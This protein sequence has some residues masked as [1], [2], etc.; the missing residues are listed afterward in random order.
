MITLLAVVLCIVLAAIAVLGALAIRA[1]TLACLAAFAR[2]LLA[3]AIGSLARVAMVARR[4]TVAMTALAP[5]TRSAT[6]IRVAC[7][8]AAAFAGPLARTIAWCVASV[9]AGAMT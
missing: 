3:F 4:V 7:A 5:F 9:G 6:A 1:A 2:L 8:P